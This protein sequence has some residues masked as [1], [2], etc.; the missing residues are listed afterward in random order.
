MI[1][2][3]DE[4]RRTQRGN[5]NAYCENDE[6][7]WFDWTLVEENADL[8]RFVSLLNARRVL[9]DVAHERAR[10]TLNELIQKARHSW[11]GVKLGHPDWCDD[12][13]SL[14]LYAELH[15][16]GQDVYVIVNAYWEPLHFE[17]PP[18]SA[19]RQWRQW[20][21][22]SRAAPEDIVPWQ[23]APSL[24]CNQYRVESRSVV[25]LFAEVG[26]GNRS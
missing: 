15:E 9:R 6:T 18:L 8:L 20:I 10:T 4:V 13:H 2:M 24:S 21:D 7:S 26:A 22:T 3:G 12:S 17:L 14:A 19:G 16:E 23:T 1:L 5:N 11:H 25:V